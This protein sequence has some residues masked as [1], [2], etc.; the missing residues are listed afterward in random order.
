MTEIIEIFILVVICV[1]VSYCM[2]WG[3]GRKQTIDE[4]FEKNI[5]DAVTYK[6]FK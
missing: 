3:A 1:V 6:R 2:G 4:L 5:I